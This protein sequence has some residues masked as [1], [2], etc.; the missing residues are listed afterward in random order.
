MPPQDSDSETIVLRGSNSDN[1]LVHALTQVYEKANSVV[2]DQVI[3]AI[4]SAMHSLMIGY[5]LLPV[6]IFSSLLSHTRKSLATYLQCRCRLLPPPL[7]VSIPFWLHKNVIGRKGVNIK[8]ITDELSGLHINFPEQGDIIVLE[9]SPEEV[10]RAKTQLTQIGVELVQRMAYEDVKVDPKFFPQLIGKG[11]ITISKIKKDHA[12]QVDFPDEGAEP[13]DTLHIEGAPSA[14]IAAKAQILLLVQKLKNMT[15]ISL[16]VPQQFHSLLIGQGGAKI[17]AIMTEC[18]DVRIDFPGKNSTSDTITIRGDKARA[19]NAKAIVLK[20]LAKVKAEN[21]QLEVPIFR[22]FHGTIIGKSGATIAKIKQETNTR[23]DVPPQGAETDVITVTGLKADCEAARDRLLAVQAELATIVEETVSFDRAT[24]KLF[25]GGLADSI[26]E[27]FGGLIISTAATSVCIRGPDTLVPAAVARC[28]D[29]KTMFSAGNRSVGDVKVPKKFQKLLV[30]SQG[31]AIKELQSSTATL[32]VMPLKKAVDAEICKIYGSE[33][34]IKAAKAVVEEKVKEWQNVVTET[35]SIESKYHGQMLARRGEFLDRLTQ[36]CGGVTVQLPKEKGSDVIKLKGGKSSVAAAAAKIREFV[37]DIKA[38]VTVEC[39][40]PVKHHK[41]VIGQG[42]KN[43]R[44]VIESF[45]VRIKMPDRKA[46]GKGGG[47]TKSGESDSAVG[48]SASQATDIIKV[49][50]RKEKCEGAIEALQALIPSEETIE[51][52]PEYHRHIIGTRGEGIRKLM[53]T[54]DVFVRFP[55]SN[56]SDSKVLVRGVTDSIASFKAALE[57]ILSELDAGAAERALKS[58]KVAL[59]IDPVHHQ[60]LIGKGGAVIEAL[61]TKHDVQV[62]FPNRK[63]T[64]S[65]EDSKKVIVTGL[66][67]SAKAAAEEMMQTVK[68][69]ESQISLELQIHSGCHRKIIG[70]GGAKIRELQSK[71][72]VRILL[73][74]GEEASD[75]VVIEGAEESCLDCREILLDIEEEWRQEEEEYGEDANL[76]QYIKPSRFEEPKDARPAKKQNFEV[77][78]AP[79][80]VAP[81]TTDNSSF[82]GLGGKPGSTGPLTS[83]WGRR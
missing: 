39:T 53:A 21:H 59:A 54:H 38:Q 69:L 36:D 34:D 50:G 44:K 14:V 51:I 22:M 72:K 82:P 6:C 47:A 37:E 13:G 2:K 40:I 63:K 19:Q 76:Q 65:D 61:R 26:G 25:A 29:F 81:N 77:R 31:A 23:I 83:A 46:G 1:S 8:K 10:G 30:G 42:G 60:K 48:A 79:W 57:P 12:V 62:D 9:G 33:A 27:L 78:D 43:I 7:Q 17:K 70:K 5:P 73:P 41:A 16:D 32:I 11:G 18:G 56:A 80:Q 49:T 75:V 28:N 20:T 66:E 45:N 52:N 24:G 15:E 67:A 64:N 35:I 3:F 58:F 71:F 4:T 74:R 55:S 68:E